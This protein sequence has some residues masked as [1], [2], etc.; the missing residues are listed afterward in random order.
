MSRA[1]R[2][3]VEEPETN[4]LSDT[5]DEVSQAASVE[6]SA[7]KRRPSLRPKADRTKI[8]RASYESTREM[9]FR[10]SNLAKTLKM[11]KYDFVF[12]LLDQGCAGYGAD[13]FLK[14]AFMKIMGET[15]KAA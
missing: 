9:E 10:I 15:A 6:M 4:D 2:H 8:V 13:G 5:A 1:R 14:D 7:R 12:K 3:V 11:R